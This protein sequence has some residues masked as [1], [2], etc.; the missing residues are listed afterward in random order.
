MTRYRFDNQE[1]KQR[2]SLTRVAFGGIAT[3]GI[4][5]IAVFVVAPGIRVLT[6][7]P[8]WLGQAMVQ[9]AERGIVSLAPKSSLIDQ[10]TALK[11][12]IKN[13]DAQLLEL[14]SLKDEN[15]KLRKELSYLPESRNVVGAQV[16]AKPSRS[17][18]NS[19]IIDRGTDQG[20]QVG[21][22]VVAQG[23]IGL[24]TISTVSKKSATVQ[25]FAGP[26][27]DGNLVVRNQDI[28]VPAKGKGSGNFEIHIPREIV[29]ADGDLLSLPEYPSLT[30]G[31]VKSISFDPRDPFQTVL[32][33]TPV[34]VQELRFVEV[35][36]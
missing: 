35:L 10:N 14:Q 1:K 27:F 9:G 2:W 31:V 7:G 21:Q 3:V 30:V 25:L 13:M 15:E 24:G 33:R 26:Q 19:L 22:V 16:L 34:N 36:Q 32:A 11:E 6:R 12:Q 23:T 29:V 5:L 20:I 17:L 18:F 28:T 8:L 4:I